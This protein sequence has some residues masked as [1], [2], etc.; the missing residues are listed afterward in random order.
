MSHSVKVTTPIPS[1]E[2]VASS[3]GVSR[4]RLDDLLALVNGSKA[5][6]G[7]QRG[8]TRKRAPKNAAPKERSI[9]KLNRSA[10]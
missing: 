10:R 9:G 5:P 1:P 4:R 6:G 2:E 3:L 8:H 7:E